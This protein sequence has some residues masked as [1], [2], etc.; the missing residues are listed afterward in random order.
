LKAI[1]RDL[2]I[3]LAALRAKDNWRNIFFLAGDWLLIAASIAAAL[4]AHMHPAVYVLSVV[5]IG[6]RQRALMNLVHQ[7]SHRKLFRTRGLN[8][9]LGKLFA[10]FPLLTSLSAY[11]CNHC[12]HHGFLWDSERD[13]KLLRYRQLGLVDPF[14]GGRRAFVRRHLLRPLLLW[15]APSNVLASLS[16]RGEPRSET[17]Q[18]VAFWA[19]LLPSLVLFGVGTEFL[20]FWLV[21]FGTSFQVIRYWA[22][23]AEHAGLRS[24]DPFQATRNWRCGMLGRFLLAPHSDWYHLTHHLLPAIPHYRLAD[25]HRLL[26]Q[27]PEYATGHHCDGFFWSRRSERPSVLEDIAAASTRQGRSWDRW[28]VDRSGAEDGEP[29]DVPAAA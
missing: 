28:A 15:H 21:P 4:A 3:E 1:P 14:G 23:M 6:S 2:R 20:V 7:A 29:R 9:S 10:A 19:M 5:I 26:V 11:V 8:D 13:P 18:R 17:L 25:A 24:S 22:E 16:W 27:V 12:R